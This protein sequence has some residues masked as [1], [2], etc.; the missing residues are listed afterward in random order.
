MRGQTEVAVPRRLERPGRGLRVAIAAGTG[1]RVAEVERVVQEVPLRPMVVPVCWFR[2]W[3]A[4]FTGVVAAVDPDIAVAAE[5]VE[6]AAV[7]AER[8]APPREAPV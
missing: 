6:S 4:T 8:W 5:T 7:V 1:I 2:F 3:D